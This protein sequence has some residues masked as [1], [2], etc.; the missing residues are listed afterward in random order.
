MVAPLIGDVNNLSEHIS[1]LYTDLG[2]FEYPEVIENM[3]SSFV[4]GIDRLLL[5]YLQ[6][7]RQD[8]IGFRQIEQVGLPI[9]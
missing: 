6:S 4:I 1:Q 5:K 3:I 2:R 9:P 7:Y 8:L